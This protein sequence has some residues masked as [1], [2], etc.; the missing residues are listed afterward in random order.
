MFE[1]PQRYPRYKK[2]QEL[3]GITASDDITNAQD[4]ELMYNLAIAAANNGNPA[5]LNQLLSQYFKK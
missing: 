2:L 4:R 3:L 5:Y 1:Y